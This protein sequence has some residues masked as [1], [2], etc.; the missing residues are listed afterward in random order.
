MTNPRPRPPQ[1]IQSI[2]NPEADKRRGSHAA[3]KLLDG[4]QAYLDIR[5]DE[6][7]PLIMRSLPD[8]HAWVRLVRKYGSPTVVEA[9]KHYLFAPAEIKAEMEQYIDN[10]RDGVTTD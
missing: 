9:H 5:D 1:G 6:D 3:R 10:V 4:I 2:R 8:S 7:W